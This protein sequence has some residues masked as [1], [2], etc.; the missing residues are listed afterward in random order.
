MATGTPIG[1]PGTILV[2]TSRVPYSGTVRSTP[3]PTSGTT[4]RQVVPV[5]MPDGPVGIPGMIVMTV[6][7]EFYYVVNVSDTMTSS[8]S[9]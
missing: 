4:G 7:K 8:D 2:G 3:P 6:V 9:F 5:A 1:V